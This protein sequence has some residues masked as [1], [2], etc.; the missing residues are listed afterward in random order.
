MELRL[1]KGTKQRF[2][3]YVCNKGVNEDDVGLLLNEVHELISADRDMA[4]LL[5]AVFA[6]VFTFMKSN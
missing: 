1:L 4:E 6:S 3:H 2:Y 5:S